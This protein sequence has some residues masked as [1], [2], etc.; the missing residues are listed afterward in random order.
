MPPPSPSDLA[1]FFASLRPASAAALQAALQLRAV[2][3]VPGTMVVSI[4]AAKDRPIDVRV[5][6]GQVTVAFD[7]QPYKAA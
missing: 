4:P 1:A 5:V 2:D 6:V 7:L 3:G